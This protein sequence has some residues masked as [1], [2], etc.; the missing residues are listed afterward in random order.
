MIVK[1]NPDGPTG[2]RLQYSFPQYATANLIRDGKSYEI[3]VRSDFYGQNYE[4]PEVVLID[5][6]AP[7][8]YKAGEGAN[9]T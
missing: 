7:K 9:R 3:A 2:L 6:A 8:R 1:F 4:T 5:K